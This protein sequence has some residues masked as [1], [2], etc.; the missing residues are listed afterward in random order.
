MKMITKVFLVIAILLICLIAWSLFLGDG[1]IL[2]N[3]WNGIAT[4][5]NSVWATV[6][7]ATGKDAEI[8]PKWKKD[9]NNIGQGQTGFDNA[10][11]AAGA[12]GGN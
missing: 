1:G 12:G 10:A 7:G 5:V 8:I 2:Q 11:G 3:T 6:T 9:T 4:R